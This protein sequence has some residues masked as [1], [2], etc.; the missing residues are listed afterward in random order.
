MDRL[1]RRYATACLAWAA[2]IQSYC[3]YDCL[4]GPTG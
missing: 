1:S 2:L 3:V 4:F